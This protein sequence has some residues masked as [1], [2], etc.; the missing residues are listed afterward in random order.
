MWNGSLYKTVK[1]EKA[2]RGCD[3]LRARTPRP[4]AKGRRRK[5]PVRAKEG[6]WFRGHV[7]WPIASRR[8]YGHG[9]RPPVWEAS[10]YSEQFFAEVTPLYISKQ[11]TT[12]MHHAPSGIFDVGNAVYDR[13][14]ED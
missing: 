9:H 3:V 6:P 12:R 2:R 14:K 7:L 11:Q 10:G 4:I 13:S 1:T 8:R 5:W